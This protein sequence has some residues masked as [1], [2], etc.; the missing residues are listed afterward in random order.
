MGPAKAG[1][2]PQ[3]QR[4]HA[5]QYEFFGPHGPALL[6]LALPAVVLLLPYA[7]NERGCAEFAPKL[8]LPG[9]APGQPLYTHAAMG[10]VA[11]WFALVL[12]L[13]L[14]LP[15]QW[16]QGVALPDGSRLTYK[17]NGGRGGAGRGWRA[18]GRGR[19]RAG[20]GRAGARRGAGALSAVVPAPRPQGPTGRA[21]AAAAYPSPHTHTP[22]RPHAA[23]HRPPPQ[24]LPQRSPCSR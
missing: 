4:Q 3:P 12:L 1:R 6:L 23:P 5:Q 20:R 18:R 15:G 19:G 11:G 24:P 13:H 22:R 2:Q 9:F 21:G 10:V 14:I 16:A 17:L 7:C 8:S